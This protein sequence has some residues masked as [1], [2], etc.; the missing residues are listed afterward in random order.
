MMKP[1]KTKKP[2]IPEISTSGFW[3]AN[4]WECGRNKYQ[5]PTTPE[6]VDFLFLYRLTVVGKSYLTRF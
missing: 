3:R 5:S 4:E 1:E 2:T 6:M